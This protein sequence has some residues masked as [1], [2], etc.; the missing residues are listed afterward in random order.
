MKESLPPS[1]RWIAERLLISMT[2]NTIYIILTLLKVIIIIIGWV[3]MI[4]NIIAWRKTK[5]N[6]KLKHVAIIFG[7]IF[8]GLILL[9]GIEFI[10]ALN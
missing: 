6:K 10:I 5:D 7:C 8:L 4:I 2:R 9:T 1:F 3:F